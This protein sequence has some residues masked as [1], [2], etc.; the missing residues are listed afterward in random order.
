MEQHLTH[1]MPCPPLPSHRSHPLCPQALP[2]PQKARRPPTSTSFMH[3][4][5]RCLRPLFFRL[6]GSCQGWPTLQGGKGWLVTSWRRGGSVK[7]LLFQT[8]PSVRGTR[9]GAQGHSGGVSFKEM[10]FLLER[11]SEP[12]RAGSRKW[13]KAWSSHQLPFPATE[14]EE[15]VSTATPL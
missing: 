13:A 1:F 2:S 10:N 5:W 6:R 11:G 9:E 8:P 15:G 12:A 3:P 14:L 4:T 7:P